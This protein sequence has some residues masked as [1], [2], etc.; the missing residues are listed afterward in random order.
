MHESALF[1][2]LLFYPFTLQVESSPGPISPPDERHN[3]SSGSGNSSAGG[4]GGS[5]APMM[6]TNMPLSDNNVSTTNMAMVNTAWD[7][8]D[9]EQDINVSVV[10][11]FTTKFF[12]RRCIFLRKI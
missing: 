10:F 7:M 2:L 1:Y 4:G 3:I 9:S 6:A 11:D 12:K 8:P 5:G